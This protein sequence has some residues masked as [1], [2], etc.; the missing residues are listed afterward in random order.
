MQTTR[1]R[2]RH[3]TRT[4][5]G[6]GGMREFVPEL[7]ARQTTLKG[8]RKRQKLERVKRSDSNFLSNFLMR[9][10]PIRPAANFCVGRSVGRFIVRLLLLDA[11]RLRSQ[12]R[13]PFDIRQAP[14]MLPN[15]RLRG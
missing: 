2:A 5:T 6:V 12:A 9:C 10:Q 13:E 4:Q 7:H 3:T 8:R 1:Q 15:N 11:N 14:K